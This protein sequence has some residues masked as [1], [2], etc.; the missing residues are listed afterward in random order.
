MLNQERPTGRRPITCGLAVTLWK[1]AR[2]AGCRLNARR[3]PATLPPIDCYLRCTHLHLSGWCVS[4][5]RLNVSAVIRGARGRRLAF[6]GSLAAGPSRLAR[7]SPPVVAPLWVVSAAAAAW[8]A[9]G[10]GSTAATA[11]GVATPRPPTMRRPAGWPPFLCSLGCVSEFA[12]E[13]L[14]AYHIS[15][16]ATTGLLLVVPVLL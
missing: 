3:L 4:P 2:P 9:G 13:R 5:F 14:A 12:T 1:A 8:W 6:S 15:C 16:A 7:R 10:L 11:A